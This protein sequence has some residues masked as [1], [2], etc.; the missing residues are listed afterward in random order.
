MARRILEVTP[1]QARL[2]RELNEAMARSRSAFGAAFSAVVFGHGIEEAAFVEMVGDT[3][4]TI[5][6]PDEGAPHR[7]PVVEEA[8]Q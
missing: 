5:E 2:L 7:A 6:V 4:L 3:Y 8:E 1:Q